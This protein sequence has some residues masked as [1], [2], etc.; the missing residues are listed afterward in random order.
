MSSYVCLF[1]CCCEESQ[2]DEKSRE[3]KGKDEL[4]AEKE[5]LLKEKEDKISSLQTEVSSLQVWILYCFGMCRKLFW[6][7][8]IFGLHLSCMF[9]L[10]SQKKGSSDSVKQL[11]KAQARVDELEK[12]VRSYVRENS[13]AYYVARICKR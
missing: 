4:V 11:G 5:K 8:Y 13:H 6:S 7:F 10:I 12:Q 3:V 2:I 1:V 9:S